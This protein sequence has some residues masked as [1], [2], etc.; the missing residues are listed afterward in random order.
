MDLL[1]KHPDHLDGEYF[2]VSGQMFAI[3]D[4]LPGVKGLCEEYGIIQKIQEN[5][6]NFFDFSKSLIDIGAEDG[7]YAILLNFNKNYCFEPNKKKCSLIW[8]NMWLK[9]KIENT[10]VYNIALGDTD[11]ETVNFNGFAEPGDN[12]NFLYENSFY[13]GKEYTITKR[14]LDSFGI[15]NVGLI[16]TD[17]EGFD[18]FVLKGGLNTI[19]NNNY[20]PILFECWDVGSFGQTQE[21]Y[22]RMMNFL[23]DLGYEILK[24]WGDVET[25][26]AIKKKSKQY[27]LLTLC[28]NKF[29]EFCG[30]MITSFLHNNTWFNDDIIIIYEENHL[31][32]DNMKK[33]QLISN[34]IK[35]HKV[36]IEDYENE[37]FDFANRLKAPNLRNVFYKFEAFRKCFVDK[38]DKCLFLDSDVVVIGDVKELFETDCDF[39]WC[40]EYFIVDTATNKTAENYDYFNSGVFVFNCK[41]VKENNF[42]DLI[43]NFIK[44]ENYGKNENSEC[45]SLYGYLGDEDVLNHLVPKYFTNVK[46]FD[47]KKYNFRVYGDNPDV[48]NFG[49]IKNAKIIH[50]VGG[51][52]FDN[53]KNCV[54]L[55]Y[56]EYY[57]YYYLWGKK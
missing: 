2:F 46:V 38:Y 48:T 11:F 44:N 26:L 36:I 32:E 28:D 23:T 1:L 37:Y 25:H 40:K 35:F 27:C 53:I 30:V 6:E 19:I 45:F 15:E 8:T 4:R 57:K 16:K 31:S 42:L 14:T 12:N 18:Y 29:V 51:E 55:P 20:P 50:M 33:L 39:G 49:A 7:N 56:Y 21:G 9:N 47:N 5:K 13:E 43:F 3:T 52:K 54:F 10:E 34:L 17:T 22:D 41:K 24:N